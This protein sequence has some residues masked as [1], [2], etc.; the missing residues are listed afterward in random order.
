[1]HVARV[2]RGLELL[3]NLV[4]LGIKHDDTVGPLVVHEN[5]TRVLGT[6]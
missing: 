6:G 4:V 1:M 3:D 5:Q 2:S